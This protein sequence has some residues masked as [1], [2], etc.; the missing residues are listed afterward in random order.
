MFF[1]FFFPRDFLEIL[2]DLF[3]YSRSTTVGG[4]CVM[5]AR[6]SAQEYARR[7]RDYPHKGEVDLE[8]QEHDRLSIDHKARLVADWM[9]NARAVVVHTGAGLS[10]PAGI[11]DFRS[12][13]TGVWSSLSRTSLPAS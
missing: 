1:Y 8:A 7:L 4:R 2:N 3:S 13:Y 10:T 12:K 6:N 9:R 11:P 5:N